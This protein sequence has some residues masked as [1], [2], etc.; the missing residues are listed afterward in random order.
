MASNA[1][2]HA[3][4]A[5]RGKEFRTLLFRAAA[6]PN[7]LRELEVLDGSTTSVFWLGQQKSE[8]P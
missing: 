3:W 4:I 6:P 1:Y 8:D 5:P 2:P 7:K